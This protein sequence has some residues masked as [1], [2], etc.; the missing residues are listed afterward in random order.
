MFS[1]MFPIAFDVSNM[2]LSSLCDVIN[3]FHGCY[4]I[5][6]L[7]SLDV[8]VTLSDDIIIVLLLDRQL[9]DDHLSSKQA[10]IV[11]YS[12]DGIPVVIPDHTI[13]T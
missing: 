13:M 3:I 8:I 12:G 11:V 7:D 2:L 1:S 5:R 9:V 6:L 4:G 10:S